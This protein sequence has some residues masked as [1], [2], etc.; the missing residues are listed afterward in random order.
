MT[1]QVFKQFADGFRTKTVVIAGFPS[2]MAV[3]GTAFT[4][5]G[6]Q[7]RSSSSRL[8]LSALKCFI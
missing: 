1:L 2:T 4:V 3:I 7:Q 5:D 8:K 6:L